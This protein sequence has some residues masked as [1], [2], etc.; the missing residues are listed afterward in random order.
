MKYKSKNRFTDT[1]T[2]NIRELLA[3]CRTMFLF[4]VFFKIGALERNAYWFHVKL[5]FIVIFGQ[6]FKLDVRA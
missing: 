1:S 3:G 4:A 2:K 6:S 5:I